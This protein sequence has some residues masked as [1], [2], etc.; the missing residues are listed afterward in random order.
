[1]SSVEV[2]VVLKVRVD[3]WSLSIGCLIGTEGALMGLVVVEGDEG[4]LSLSL[5]F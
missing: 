5:P 2:Y 3:R 1:M 4:S